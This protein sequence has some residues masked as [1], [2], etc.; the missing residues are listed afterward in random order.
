MSTWT[1]RAW[2]KD[3]L[4]CPDC[5]QGLASE[6]G[7]L[8]CPAGHAFPVVG[9]IP[10]FTPPSSYADSFGFEWTTFPRLQLDDQVRDESERTFRAKTGLTPEDVRGKTVFD[11]GCGMGRF[12]HVVARWGAERVVGVDISDAIRAAAVNLEAFPSVGLAQADLVRLPFA[13]ST[14]DVVFSVGVLHH[15]PSTRQGLA[16]I[17][18]L[19]RPGGILAVW[20]YS[21]RLRWGLLGGELLRPLT[22]R[23][24]P[25]ALLS[26]VRWFVPR[27]DRI[28]RR[29]PVLTAPLDFV[30]PTSNHPDPEWRVLDTFDWYSPRYQWKHSYAEVERWFRRL[31]FTGVDRLAVPVSVRGRRPG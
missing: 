13:P 26:R 18:R 16:H 17:A 15:T 21:R 4:A 24:E 12:S 11:A 29:F 31:G 7:R 5:G 23:M 3:L 19:V 30:V 2:L 10:R 20:V 9:G 28:K 25:A 6:R 27:V 22:T 14:F 1:E 8:A